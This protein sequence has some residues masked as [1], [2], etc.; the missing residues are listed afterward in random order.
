V[1]IRKADSEIIIKTISQLREDRWLGNVRRQWP[2]FIWHFSDVKNV[3]GILTRGRIYSRSKLVETGIITVDIANQEIIDQTPWAHEY[4]RLY[5]R[6]RTPMQ[7]N[8][9]GI[10]PRTNV[11]KAHC[12]VPVFLLFD[13]PELLTRE[14]CF[15]TDGNFAHFGTA[16]QHTAEQFQALPF[17]TIYHEGPVTGDEKREIIRARCAEVLFR[18]ELTLAP[19]REIVCRTAAER[20]TLLWLLEPELAQ[21]WKGRIRVERAGEGLFFRNWAYVS[22][23]RYADN[24]ITCSFR[25]G[26]GTYDFAFLVRTPDKKERRYLGPSVTAQ[27]SRFVI[28]V[29]DGAPE[30]VF[31]EVH[32][33]GELAYRGYLSQRSV[34]SRR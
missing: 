13:A 5:M 25:A 8:I 22:E 23:V 1:P 27:K 34:L 10:R 15:F 16:R 32:I 14:E 20:E 21:Q 6:P 26:P 28:K 29:G 12:P 30:R 11:G 7:Y 33:E 4:A 2:N 18:D 17:R 3:A 9:E 19:L 24:E 31:V